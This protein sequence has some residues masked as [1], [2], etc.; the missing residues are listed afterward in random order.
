MG[1]SVIQSRKT[2]HGYNWS[3]SCEQSCARTEMFESECGLTCIL[4]PEKEIFYVVDDGRLI[5]ARMSL[6]WSRA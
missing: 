6:Y 3:D 2:I 1:Y 4:I 5:C